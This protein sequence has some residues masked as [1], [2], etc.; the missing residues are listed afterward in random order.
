M[1][2]RYVYSSSDGPMGL[3]DWPTLSETIIHQQRVVVMLDYVPNQEANPQLRD[4]WANM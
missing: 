2:I 1:F 3:D 4:K